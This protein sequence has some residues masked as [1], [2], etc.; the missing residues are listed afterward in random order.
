[1]EESSL[2]LR[3]RPQ[4]FLGPS[5]PRGIAIPSDVLRP[6]SLREP[7]QVKR[8]QGERPIESR[9]QSGWMGSDPVEGTYY[10]TGAPK[11]SSASQVGGIEVAVQPGVRGNSAICPF[12][13]PD[14]GIVTA[15]HELQQA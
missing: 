12:E 1:V 8:L 11:G 13:E 14:R 2:A 3:Q 4:L 15:G 6:G 7:V 5:T 9:L 10:I